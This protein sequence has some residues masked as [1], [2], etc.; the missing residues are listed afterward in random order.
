MDDCVYSKHNFHRRILWLPNSEAVKWECGELSGS[1]SV[2]HS[3]N[4]ELKLCSA[5]AQE[6]L[7]QAAALTCCS[8]ASRPQLFPRWRWAEHCAC[9]C[10]PNIILSPHTHMHVRAHPSTVTS[11]LLKITQSSAVNYLSYLICLLF[12]LLDGTWSKG[13]VGL[14]YS[15]RSEGRDSGSPGK[16]W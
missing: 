7:V 5:G 9:V 2:F 10:V 4:V 8:A 16:P 3:G 11:E 15:L 6:A 1:L 14:I 12:S 13:T